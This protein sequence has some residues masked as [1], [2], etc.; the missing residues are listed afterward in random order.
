MIPYFPSLF[1][2]A[3]PFENFAAVGVSGKKAAQLA[4]ENWPAELQLL[5]TVAADG[6]IV[7]CIGLVR[8]DANSF[9]LGHPA[10][11]PGVYPEYHSHDVAVVAARQEFMPLNTALL[12]VFWLLNRA[13]FPHEQDSASSTTVP[14]EV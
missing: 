10:Q 4:L 12:Y 3:V 6:E 11:I 8:P 1:T 13:G 9:G 5:F 7:A 2:C 14:G